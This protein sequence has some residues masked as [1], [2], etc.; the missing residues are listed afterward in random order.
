[1]NFSAKS[2]KLLAKLSPKYILPIH[3]YGKLPI[4]N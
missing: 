2:T 1:L 3:S 4:V